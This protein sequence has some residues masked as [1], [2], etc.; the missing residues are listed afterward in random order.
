MLAIG[1][2]F[3]ASSILCTSIHHLKRPES[4][5]EI[6]KKYR[7]HLC[8]DILTD[9]IEFVDGEIILN[10]KAAIHFCESFFSTVLHVKFGGVICRTVVQAKLDEVV[11]QIL[12]DDN[13]RQI[14]EKICKRI[15][16]C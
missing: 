16:F 13:S 15:A 3:L 7:C 5:E 11:K 6:F 2:L 9:N 4:T 12:A 1:L 8:Q 14:S 10:E